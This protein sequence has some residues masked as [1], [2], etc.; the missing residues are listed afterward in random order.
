M[1]LTASIAFFVLTTTLHAGQNVDVFVNNGETIPF[2]VIQG[3][4]P[5]AS[6][7]LAS[8]DVVVH[9]HAAMYPAWKGN[10]RVI[11]VDVENAGPAGFS[12]HAL[13]YSLLHERDRVSLF[14][15]R[16]RDVAGERL[17]P[18]FL[19]YAIAHEIAHILQGVPHHSAAGVMK[20]NWDWRDFADMRHSRLRFTPEDIRMIRVKE[21][22]YLKEVAVR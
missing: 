14:Y 11:V 1:K 18:I 9:W 19:A 17:A 5:L 8:A 16:I 7:I 12:R 3:A 13:G 2:R 20:A 4:K 10:N 21:F 15:D 22:S 6:R